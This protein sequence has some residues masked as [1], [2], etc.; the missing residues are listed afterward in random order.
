MLVATCKDTEGGRVLTL[1]DFQI[2]SYNVHIISN[3]FFCF[4]FSLFLFRFP[5]LK[6]TDTFRHHSFLLPFLSFTL[7]NNSSSSSSRVVLL[8]THFSSQNYC[9]S[10]SLSSCSSFLRFIIRKGCSLVATQDSTACTLQLLSLLIDHLQAHHIGLLLLSM[11]YTNTHTRI[12]THTRTYRQASERARAR[13][14]NKRDFMTMVVVMVLL[15]HTLSPVY[16]NP[17]QLRGGLENQSCGVWKLNCV[18]PLL[19]F[20][21]LCGI[22][23]RNKLHNSSTSPTEPN[24]RLHFI[25]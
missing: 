5:F 7:S 22:L 20:F 9:A 18:S 11:F 13:L 19:S 6:Q 2:L 8:F 16:T 15:M 21:L 4:P 14:H 24:L 12:Y 1:S 23:V 10:T 3:P 25:R 17:L